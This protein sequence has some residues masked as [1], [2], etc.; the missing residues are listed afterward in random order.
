MFR[1]FFQVDGPGK[2]A[3]GERRRHSFVWSI[4]QLPYDFLMGS[5]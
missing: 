1:L 5:M 2:I 4:I 3:H